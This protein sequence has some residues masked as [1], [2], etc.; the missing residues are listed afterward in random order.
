MDFLV[1]WRVGLLYPFDGS[2]EMEVSRF[3][4]NN[5]ASYV[6]WDGCAQLWKRKRK[7]KGYF[8]D[9]PRIFMFD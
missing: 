1:N 4:P 8:Y 3:D 2:Q 6:K 9:F 5:H 7:R